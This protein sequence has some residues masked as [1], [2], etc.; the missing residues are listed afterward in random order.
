VTEQTQ[1]INF[2]AEDQYDGKVVM[3]DEF[4]DAEDIPF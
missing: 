3:V 1:Q 2:M 4:V